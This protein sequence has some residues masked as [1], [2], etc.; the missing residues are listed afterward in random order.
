MVWFSS[1][2]DELLILFKMNEVNLKYERVLLEVFFD[3]VR[4]LT[5]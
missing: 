5:G 3:T 1:H 2:A 4:Y